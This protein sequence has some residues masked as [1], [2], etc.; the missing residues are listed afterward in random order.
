M[1]YLQ[2]EVTFL[3]LGFFAFCCFAFVVK[4]VLFTIRL[5]GASASLF[6]ALAFC[7][8]ESLASFP[9]NQYSSE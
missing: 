6:L 9:C 8:S 1:L 7:E 3:Q 2:L 4:G 5:L